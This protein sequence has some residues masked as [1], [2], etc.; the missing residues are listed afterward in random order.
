VS[1]ELQAALRYRNHAEL[2]RMIAA[3]KGS[4][5]HLKTLLA[6]AEDFDRMAATL[7]AVDKARRSGG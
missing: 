3:D 5:K 1:E 6:V 4:L 2:I 7:E